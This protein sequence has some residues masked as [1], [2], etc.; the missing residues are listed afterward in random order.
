VN[1]KEVNKGIL[2]LLSLCNC[3]SV[4]FC[5]ALLFRIHMPSVCKKPN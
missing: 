1:N 4:Q 5:M 2:T 3:V